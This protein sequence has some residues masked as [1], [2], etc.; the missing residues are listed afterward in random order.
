MSATLARLNQV[1]PTFYV[2][3]M[4][5]NLT[6]VHTLIEHP[7]RV[8]GAHISENSLVQTAVEMRVSECAGGGGCLR[9]VFGANIPSVPRTCWVNEGIKLT[10]TAPGHSPYAATSRN[11]PHHCL[12]WKKWQRR[13]GTHAE[14]EPCSLSTCKGMSDVP[15][16]VFL[17]CVFLCM[18]FIVP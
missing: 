13:G 10:S 14:K 17:L 5:T 6:L 3:T 15:L 7:L 1:K 4:P 11:P 8:I 9:N 18:Q 2:L 16:S 12:I